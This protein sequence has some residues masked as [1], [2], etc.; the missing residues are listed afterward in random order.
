MHVPDA[1][2]RITPRHASHLLRQGVH[3][4]VISERLGHSSVGFTLDTYGH[5]LPG[6]QAEAAK[7]DR[8]LG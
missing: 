2:H 5:L 7:I 6:M 1:H 3:P 8:A 4:K